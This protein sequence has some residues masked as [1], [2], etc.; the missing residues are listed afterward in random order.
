MNGSANSV[1]T[2]LSG[3]SATVGIKLTD[4]VST[5][6]DAT[7]DYVLI[8]NLTGTNVGGIF[9]AVPVFLGGMTPTNAANFYVVTRSN[10]VV[11]HYSSLG[12]SSAFATPNPAVHNQL[13]TFSVNAVATA[14]GA[15]ITSVTLDVSSIGGSS[16]R[17]ARAMLIVSSL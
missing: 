4:L 12:V 6:L 15:T 2:I 1:T 10:S 7:A 17:I 5:N 8:T 11:L 3:S 9:S 14:P 16:L 13:V